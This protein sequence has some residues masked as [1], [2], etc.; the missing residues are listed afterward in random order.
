MDEEPTESVDSDQPR[1][2]LRNRTTAVP[3]SSSHVLI[4]SHANLPAIG[5]CMAEGRSAG[6]A[7]E[8]SLVDPPLREMSQLSPILE[9]GQES[10]DTSSTEIYTPPLLQPDT[11]SPHSRVA[12]DTQTQTRNQ[13]TSHRM[14][15]FFSRRSQLHNIRKSHFSLFYSRYVGLYVN[16]PTFFKS[17]TLYKNNKNN[18]KKRILNVRFKPITEF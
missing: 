4:T 15:N 10:Q 3:S 18:V 8:D 13:S 5:V 7:A 14:N 9:V 16:F 2:Q 1:Y 17:K 11:I 6:E 12:L